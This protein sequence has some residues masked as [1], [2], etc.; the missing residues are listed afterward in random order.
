MRIT[1]IET[2]LLQAPLGEET[3]WSSQCAFK[4]RKSLLVRIDTDAEISGWGEA[5]QYGPGEPVASMVHDVMAPLILG[6]NPLAPEVL[7]EIMYST[8]L[9]FG[10]KGT[11]IEA[12]SGLDIALWDIVGKAS[13]RPIHECLGGAWRAS[14]PTYATGLYYRGVQI[15]GFECDAAALRAEAKSFVE[16]GFPAVKMKVGL[17]RPAEDLRRIEA[18]REV[19][20]DERQLMVDA[21]HAYNQHSAKLMARGMEDLGIFWFEEPVHPEDRKGYRQLRRDTSLAIAGGE[22]EYTR[23]GFREWFEE[24]ALDICQPD[25]CCAGGI[26]EV[27]KIAQLAAAFHV[28]CIPHV[29]GSGVALAAGLHL[30]ATLPPGPHTAMPHPPFNVPMLEWDT[31]PN[32]LRTQLLLTS[33]EPVNGTVAIPQGP[34]LGIEINKTALQK[35]CQMQRATQGCASQ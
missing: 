23:W 15:P 16:A 28:T 29:W 20:G 26:S 10:R 9:D 30:L 11:A 31:N 2:Y 6:R 34:G 27:R 13:G 19:I 25:L 7:W 1:G 22:C 35:W 4:R 5:G 12:I 3:F 24:E 33:L 14:V 8:T 32:P 21:N 17:F 18:V